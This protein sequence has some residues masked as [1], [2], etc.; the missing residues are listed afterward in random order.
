MYVKQNESPNASK[1][2]TRIDK[3]MRREGNKNSSMKSIFTIFGITKYG[4]CF[5]T[6]KMLLKN[7]YSRFTYRSQCK[8]IL[9]LS[10]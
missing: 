4:C 6:S 2:W 3:K 8:N 9:Q 10:S 7:D 5:L 1:L